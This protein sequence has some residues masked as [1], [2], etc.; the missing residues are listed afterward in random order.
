ME[1]CNQRRECFRI[2]A[3]FATEVQPPAML[4][5]RSHFGPEE[6]PGRR[7]VLSSRPGSPKSGA[8]VTSSR[9]SGTSASAWLSSGSDVRQRESEMANAGVP[10]PRA[11]RRSPGWKGRRGDRRQEPLVPQSDPGK[12]TTAAYI[13]ER[14]GS[15]P[16]RQDFGPR[17][18]P[19][20]DTHRPRPGL[21]VQ[22]GQW[23]PHLWQ[24]K[25]WRRCAFLQGATP[26][27]H[28]SAL[29]WLTNRGL[30]RSD[31]SPS[32]FREIVTLKPVA[33]ASACGR[34]S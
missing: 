13:P 4:G 28:R 26:L 22:I 8:S 32:R 10:Q 12:S 7:R 24:A 18:F 6:K 31:S 27:H 5:H 29:E 23:L 15:G 34:W 19:S 3:P 1:S 9:W 25:E 11:D 33:Q 14:R 30:R 16:I 21:A 2:V 20:G 17:E